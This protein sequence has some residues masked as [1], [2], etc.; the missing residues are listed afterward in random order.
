MTL[1]AQ[2]TNPRPLTVA[3]V[4][5]GLSLSGFLDG[6]LLHQILQWHHM[7]TSVGDP[8]ISQDPFLNS[9]GDGL[10]HLTTWLLAVLGIALLWRARNRPDVPRSGRILLGSILLGAGLFDLVEGLVDHHLLGIHHVNPQGNVLA[11]DLAFLAFGALLMVTGWAVMRT[12]RAYVDA[13]DRRRLA[14]ARGA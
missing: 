11:W 12:D 14:R 8:A 7:F 13:R 5:L 9:A 1:D 6:I 4:V 10:F 3:G 2:R